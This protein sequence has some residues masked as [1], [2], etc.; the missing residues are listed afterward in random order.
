MP[1]C[2]KTIQQGYSTSIAPDLLAEYAMTP[3]FLQKSIKDI[4]RPFHRL[5]QMGA[6]NSLSQRVLDKSI[7]I[8]PFLVAT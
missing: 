6:S 7:Q 8:Q 2:N 4:K 5:K 1:T 3:A